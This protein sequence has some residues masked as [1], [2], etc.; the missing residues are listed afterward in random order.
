LST[1][2]GVVAIAD[3]VI[4]DVQKEAEAIIM[5]AENE[6][7]ETLRVAKEQA[8]KTYHTI[9][10][11]A[12]Q[13]AEGEKRKIASVTEVELRNRL[14]QTKEDIVDET[15]EKALAKLKDFVETD[16]Y[17]AYLIKL[18]E[19]LAKKMDQNVL[20]IEVNA[21]DKEFLTSELLKKV[22]KKLKI[23]L[24]LSEQTATYIGGCKVQTQDGKIVYDGTLDNRLQ[25][26]KPELRAQ[27]AK[28]LFGET[29]Q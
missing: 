14:L 10:A 15:F 8:D 4:G 24:T 27:I 25:E 1:K 16:E 6:A 29:S 9:L 22:S 13:K 17:H 5:A 18:V 7:K 23:E 3:E 21:K 11:E 20:V 26:L 2:S 12:N 19:E 28:S